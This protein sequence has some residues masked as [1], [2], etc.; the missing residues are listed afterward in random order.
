VASGMYGPG[1]T[2]RDASPTPRAR[3]VWNVLIYGLAAIGAGLLILA[4][5]TD[6]T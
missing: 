2:H 5:V 1:Q 3:L 6:Q 4:A